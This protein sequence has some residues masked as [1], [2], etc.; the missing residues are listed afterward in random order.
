MFLEQDLVKECTF[1]I[2]REVEYVDCEVNVKFDKIRLY[3]EKIDRLL[4]KKMNKVV[5]DLENVNLNSI[6]HH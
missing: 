4:S 1:E 3:P 5:Y 2:M 6:H